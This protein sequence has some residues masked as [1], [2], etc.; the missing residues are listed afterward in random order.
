MGVVSLY[1]S[2][3]EVVA[4]LRAYYDKEEQY[5]INFYHW[6][7]TA[8]RTNDG[9]IVTVGSRKF[10]LHPVLGIVIREVKSECGTSVC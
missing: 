2:D 4:S 9:V 8:R 3:D 10:L 1:A 6:L 7:N 5:S